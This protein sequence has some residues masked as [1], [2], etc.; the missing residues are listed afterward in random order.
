MA[1]DGLESI[2]QVPVDF[3]KDGS[4]FIQKCTKP[5]KKGMTRPLPCSS[6]FKDETN[7]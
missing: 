6:S 1:K 7:H 3:V 4:A 5:D 2:T